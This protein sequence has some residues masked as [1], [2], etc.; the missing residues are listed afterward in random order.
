MLSG[1]PHFTLGNLIPKPDPL[2]YAIC[3][4]RYY[5]P[6][7]CG[8]DRCALEKTDGDFMLSANGIIIQQA[9]ICEREER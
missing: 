8:I 4:L 6:A 1:R 5:L 2:H 3:E 7:T 9:G